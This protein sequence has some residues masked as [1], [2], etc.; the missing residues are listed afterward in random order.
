MKT[1]SRGCREAFK[2]GMSHVKLYFLCGV[3]GERH[4]D[5]DGI[6]ELAEAI[7]EVGKE[8]TGRHKEVIASVSAIPATHTPYQWNGMQSRE[9]FRWAGDYLHRQ[10]RNKLVKI[11]QHDIET[12]LLEGILT[13]GDRG[14]SVRASTKRG[15][16]VLGSDGWKECFKPDVWWNAFK[17][18]GI[19]VDFYRSRQRLD[20]G[21]AARGT[22]ST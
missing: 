21:E 14:G 18:A 5:L 3:P 10:K 17:D 22:T 4:A 19:D 15:N 13:R 6:V 20:H 2:A 11:K 7:S 9:Y 8:V 12:S 1:S 16:A